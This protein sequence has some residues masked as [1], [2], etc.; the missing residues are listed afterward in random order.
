M[1]TII[2]TGVSR[3]D[4]EFLQQIGGINDNSL[5]TVLDPDIVEDNELNYPQIISHSSHYDSDKI[6]TILQ[7]GKNKF[8][9]FSTNIMQKLMN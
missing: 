5:I 2:A 8:T 9:I 7:T 4:N 3:L 1:Y 6:S